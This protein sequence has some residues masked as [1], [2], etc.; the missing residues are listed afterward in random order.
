MTSENLETQHHKKLRQ[1]GN[2]IPQN[3][4][5]FTQQKKDRHKGYFYNMVALPL[6]IDNTGIH[7]FR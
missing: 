2:T 5:E 6:A 3:N 4:W 1:R 7:I